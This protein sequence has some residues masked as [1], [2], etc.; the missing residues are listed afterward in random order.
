MQADSPM[1]APFPSPPSPFPVGGLK[2]LTCRNPIHYPRPH[3]CRV[4]V[5]PTYVCRRERRGCFMFVWKNLEKSGGGEGPAH[6]SQTHHFD[7]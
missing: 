7:N 5:C 6:G 1:T 2:D 4:V 3:T